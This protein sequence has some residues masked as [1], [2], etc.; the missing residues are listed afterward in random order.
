ML[1]LKNNDNNN[2]IVIGFVFLGS[3]LDEGTNRDQ[4]T[5]RL[6]TMEEDL[7]LPGRGSRKKSFFL[8]ALYPP[9]LGLVAIGTFFLLLLL[10][11]LK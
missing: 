4:L 3:G 6:R 1:M 11:V 9:P 2:K 7:H 5:Q 10:F 8:V